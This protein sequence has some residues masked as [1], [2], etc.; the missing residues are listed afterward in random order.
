MGGLLVGLAG[1]VLMAIPGLGAGGNSARGV[2]LITLALMSYGVAINLARPL[3]QRNGA[4]P[5]V[6]R[7]QG[8]ALVLTAPFGGSALLDA[9]WTMR[10][11][12]SVLALGCLGTAVANAVMATASGRLGAA[13][14]SATLF[15]IPVVALA[16]GML[17]R[18]ERVAT[19][20]IAGSA[21]CLAGAWL[22]RRA[23]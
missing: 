19:I 12:L 21:L 1:A 16:L 23:R 7:A 14:S 15:L 22:V 6:W 4:L 20:A 8:V 13:R 2:L 17:V 11:F 5:V 9:H 3:Q 10:S 18:H